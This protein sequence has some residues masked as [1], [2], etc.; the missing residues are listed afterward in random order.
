MSESKSSDWEF[1]V[2]ENV[3]VGEFPEETE[4]TGPE[5]DKMVEEFGKLLERPETDAHV[6]VLRSREPYS[7]E[8]Q[9]NLRKSAEASVDHGVTRWAVVAAGTKQLTM[10]TT[11]DI[12]GLE[13]ETFDLGEKTDAIEWA[14]GD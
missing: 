7:K 4:L 1:Y 12:D 3:I 13:V 11:A 2:E 6:T 10:K 9:E 14:R 5:S 8:G